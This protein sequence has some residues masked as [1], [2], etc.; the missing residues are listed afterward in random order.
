VQPTNPSVLLKHA[1][2]DAAAGQQFIEGK[3]ELPPIFAVIR[4]S[5]SVLGP[6]LSGSNFVAK[7]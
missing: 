4:I 5:P 7:L 2:D 6:F 3:F 1:I